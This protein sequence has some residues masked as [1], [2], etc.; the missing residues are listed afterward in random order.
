V[1]TAALAALAI[2]TALT[3]P[4]EP[5][6]ASEQRAAQAAAAPAA[7]AAAASPAKRAARYLLRAQNRDGG[8]GG[9]RGQ[10]SSQLYT[11]WAV[12]GLAAARRNPRDVRRRGGR[13]AVRY[14]RSQLGGLTDIGEIERTVL[15][16][17]A[18]GLSPRSFGGR[19][20]IADV[21]RRRRPNGSI[22]EYVSYTAFG[23]LALE[24]S[25]AP[26]WKSA[27][28]YLERAQNDDGGFGIAPAVSSDTDMT[29][30]VLQALAAVGRGGGEVARKAVEYL[31]RMQGPSGGLGATGGRVPNAQST[32]YA[33]Q[34]LLAA[35]GEPGAV[36]RA[37]AYLKRLQRPDGSIRYSRASRQTPA[38]VTAQALM[39]LRRRPL[40][41]AVVPRRKPIRASAAASPVDEVSGGNGEAAS[42]KPRSARGE[43]R[44]GASAREEPAA[45]AVA[46]ATEREE[47]VPELASSAAVGRE[48]EEDGLS[49]TAIVLGLGAALVL[50]GMLPWRSRRKPLDG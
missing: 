49:T 7:R 35:G 50:A 8:F 28:T 20:L 3:V 45:T 16:L 41:L 42:T 14:L 36:G 40:P 43:E 2:A 13:T 12:L 32:A 1:A 48:N 5:A 11:G 22:A 44:A 30:A 26:V 27:V 6:R 18:A 39:A 15:V 9:D 31:V 23:I 37:L 47:V 34:G 21:V 17:R 4:T 38:W 33:A 24:A 10:S 25:G 46:R 29:G 19:N